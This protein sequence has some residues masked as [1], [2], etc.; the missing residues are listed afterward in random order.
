MNK[1][2]FVTGT[3]TEVGK[4]LVTTALIA[5]ATASGQSAFGIKPI[6]AGCFEQGDQ[7]VNEDALALMDANSIK[8]DYAQVNPIA[9]KAPLAP[10]I[11]A[12]KEGRR[13]MM[14]RLEGLVRGSLM[15]K[16][17]WRFIEGAGGW[18]VPL[19]PGE[20]LSDL[21]VRLACPVILVV[22]IRLGCLNHALLT[23]DAI[24]NDGLQLA[25]WVANCIDDQTASPEE[26]IETLKYLLKAPC[27]GI[28]P[29][30]SNA[31]LG[32]EVAAYVTLPT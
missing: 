7:W 15:L 29:Y 28:V 27:L 20:Y 13:L 9:L 32:R 17:D 14:D 30:C 8:L 24:R 4:T 16:A 10:H 3:D 26:N 25:G 19:S 31:A 23:A 11:A 18:R 2:F 5:K 21:P 1:T 22:A 6:A 12:A